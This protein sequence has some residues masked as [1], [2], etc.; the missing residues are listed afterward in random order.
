MAQA[1]FSRFA[2]LLVFFLAF[3][4][5]FYKLGQVP[6]SLYWDEAAQLMDVKSVIETGKDVH[7][8]S[9]LQTIFPS[10]GDY[11]LPIYIWLATFPVRIFG[12]N[13]FAFRS[14]SAVVGLLTMFVAGLIAVELLFNSTHDGFF[15]KFLTWLKSI[16][17]KKF[18]IDLKN[19]DLKLFLATMFVVAVSPW[20]I[21]FSR[22]AFEGHLGQLLLSL[23][24]LITLKANRQKLRNKRFIYLFSAQ[25]LAGLAT[26][27]YFSVRFVWPIIFFAIILLELLFELFTP[28]FNQKDLLKKLISLLP[29]LILPLVIYALLL[30]PMLKSPY[31]AA[32]NQFRMS[33]TSILNVKNW[34]VESQRLKAIAG[35]KLIDKFIYHRYVL[36][37]RELAKNYADH[38]SLNYLFVDGDANLRHG[39]GEHGV[40]LFIFMPIFLLG[41]Y[42][43]FLQHKKEL[44]ILIIWWLAALLPACVPEETPHSL[45]SLNA[46]VPLSIIIGYG[47][48]ELISFNSKLKIS[49]ASFVPAEFLKKFRVRNKNLKLKTLLLITYFSLIFLSVYQ[50]THFYFIQYPTDS[51]YEW[52][53]KYKELALLIMNHQAS[54]RTVWAEPFDN[55][56]YLWLL[57]YGDFKATDIQSWP[58]EDFQ[59]KKIENIEFSYFDW[60]KLD[61]LDHKLIIAGQKDSLE[62]SLSQA[63]YPPKWRQ[64][65]YDQNGEIKFIVVGYG[66]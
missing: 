29:T 43:L 47:L 18:K 21:M 3:F 32:N 8:N 14:V 35:N 40:F 16:F 31:Y 63:S 38:L 30:I 49:S 5:R 55:R 25:L 42:K 11:K 34:P 36:I 1:T 9:W 66:N 6:V 64:D 41:L 45:R 48:Y 61:S 58:R 59:F 52:Q 26:Y 7:G 24:V 2:I 17:N 20:S 39:T 57:A 12:A 28:K 27:A 65:I 22:T 44:L 4:L 33:T 13:E 51:A 46:L 10:Y 37:G 15:S 62:Y 50:F 60:T 23:A 54:V 19:R 56:F 53:D